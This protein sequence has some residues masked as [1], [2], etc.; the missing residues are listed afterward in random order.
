MPSCESPIATPVSPVPTPACGDG[1]LVTG[2]SPV[3]LSAVALMLPRGVGMSLLLTSC[4][5][6][7]LL[8]AILR[9]RGR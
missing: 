4:V 9:R 8:S 3:D 5:L 6:V 2:Y 7:A 1:G